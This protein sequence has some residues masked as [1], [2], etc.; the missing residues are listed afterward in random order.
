M[1]GSYH[2]LTNEWVLWA[3]LPHNTDWSIKSYITITSFKYLEDVIAILQN[4][5]PI[6]IENCMLFIMKKGINPTW[7]DQKNREGG[8]FS[9]KVLNKHV[10]K[11]WQSLTY[12]VLGNT[13]SNN[14]L[15]N[16]NVTGIT[17]SPK[18]NF[19]ILKIWMSDCKLQNPGLITNDIKE[20]T[21]FGCIFKKHTPQY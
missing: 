17:I 4:L 3:H 19:C 8:F 7:E 1:D 6:L 21:N 13:I 12:S 18:K 20:L 2:T 5:E 16:E 15:F 10:Y 14:K 11:A 9:Y